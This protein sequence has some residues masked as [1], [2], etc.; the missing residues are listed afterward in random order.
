MFTE[1]APGIFSVESRFVEG[2][3]GIVLG[4]RGAL[5]ID[6]SN[7]IDEGQAMADFIRGHGFAP[8]RLLLTHG[9]N[10]HILGAGPLAGGEV[11]AHARTP[12]VIAAQVPG[13]AQR[14]GVP[15]EEATRRVIRPTVTFRE[16]LWID[17]GGARVWAFPTPGHSVDGVSIYV[18]RARLL[19]AGDSVVTG[20]VPAI[21]NGDSRVLQ[22]SLERLQRLEIETLV[23]GHG[24]VLHGADAVQD[25]LGWQAAYL[26]D[27]RESVRAGLAR[28]ASPER[29][30][31]E[32]AFEEFIGERLPGDR[33]NMPKR[34]RDTVGKIV[35]EV[36][37]ERET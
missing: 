30:V 6:G 1:L 5:A 2:K 23:P 22:R 31:H 32:I 19:F 36:L 21:A 14:W 27:V 4:E 34:H 9:H 24:R 13:F 10:D 37:S 16:E 25:W 3:N 7:F 26:A 8:D 35:A 18:E 17:L 15:V 12:G 20:I 29:V 11:F 33:H 28:G